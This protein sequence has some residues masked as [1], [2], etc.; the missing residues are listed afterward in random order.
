MPDRMDEYATRLTRL[1]SMLE[2]AIYNKLKRC[3][4]KSE[5]FYIMWN[6]KTENLHFFVGIREFR[7][8]VFLLDLG[9]TVLYTK[10]ALTSVRILVKNYV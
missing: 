4:N 5:T 6:A 7:K 10:V 9:S 8:I 2:F 1:G 3:W